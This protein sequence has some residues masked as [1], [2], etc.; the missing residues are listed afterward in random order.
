MRD[1]SERTAVVLDEQPL[2][3]EAMEQLLGRVGVSI[4]GKTTDPTEA[5]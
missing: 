2:W 4:V 3:L 1:S 5:L